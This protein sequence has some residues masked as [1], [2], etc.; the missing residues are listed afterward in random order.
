MSIPSDQ[1]QEDWKLRLRR[2]KY[3]SFT[4]FWFGTPPRRQV[5]LWEAGS[6]SI[7]KWLN[8]ET[9]LRP[10]IQRQRVL[11]R[12]AKPC[13]SIGNARAICHPPPSIFS[14]YY[15]LNPPPSLFHVIN[16][17][18]FY[19]TPSSLWH[20]ASK[21]LCLLLLLWWWPWV[22]SLYILYQHLFLCTRHFCCLTTSPDDALMSYRP[23]WAVLRD[24]A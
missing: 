3:L 8:G 10:G 9:W 11:I 14:C 16:Y 18:T 5:T 12:A 6:L 13:T 21:Q 4:N 1:Y 15:W 20:H 22:Q 17:V 24:R 19:P 23:Y 7:S 2:E